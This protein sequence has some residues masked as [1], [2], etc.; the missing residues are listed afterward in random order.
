MKVAFVA[1]S[2]PVRDGESILIN[3]MSGLETPSMEILPVCP[4]EGSLGCALK[5]RG[6]RIVDLPFKKADSPFQV[7]DLL[8]NFWSIVTREDVDIIYAASPRA[9]R[10]G[11]SISQVTGIPLVYHAFTGRSL[12]LQILMGRFA[13]GIVCASRHVA[14]RFARATVPVK[15]I[16]S[17]VEPSLFTS[18]RDKKR[19]RQKWGLDPDK[20]VIGLV[21]NLESNGQADMVIRTFKQMLDDIPDSILLI[22]GSDFLRGTYSFERYLLRMIRGLDL[23]N[24][25]FIKRFTS[26]FEELYGLTDIL[27]S[28]SIHEE[29]LFPLVE[30]MVSGVP[31]V[32]ARSAWVT[33]FVSHGET[34]ILV[35]EGDEHE[36]RQTVYGLLTEPSQAAKLGSAA[37]AAALDRFSAE[38]MRENLNIFLNEVSAAKGG[39]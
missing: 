27:V 38:K 4:M 2:I 13:G 18:I 26:F 31:V 28:P 17:G 14:S 36:L 6:C 39:R 12:G 21:T 19:L 35:T 3:L 16:Y 32:A 10:Y 7:A 24:R 23:Q 8:A 15:V 34:G 37:S 9:A 29:N 30:A 11:F 22:A 25:V 1:D 20:P 33:E 5:N